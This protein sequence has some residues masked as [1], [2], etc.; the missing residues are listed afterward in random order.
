VALAGEGIAAGV[1]KHVR[2]G[3][4]FPKLLRLI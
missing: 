2:M 3:F 1:A 4:Q